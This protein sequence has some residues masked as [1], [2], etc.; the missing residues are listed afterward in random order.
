MASLKISKVEMENLSSFFFSK[1]NS[2]LER[3]Q[4]NF[5]ILEIYIYIYVRMRIHV[6]IFLKGN[7]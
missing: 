3:Q 2:D 1:K 5:K 7:R 4:Y 6:R